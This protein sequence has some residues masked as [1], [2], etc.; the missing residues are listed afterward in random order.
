[1]PPTAELMDTAYA[2][3]EAAGVPEAGDTA[4]DEGEPA[5]AAAEKV[6]A[7]V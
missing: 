7:K 3:S 2:D 5:R 6:P 4:G 1:M